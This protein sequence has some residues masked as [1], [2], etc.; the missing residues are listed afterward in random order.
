MKIAIGTTY[1]FEDEPCLN[2]KEVNRKTPDEQSRH[3]YQI[4]TVIRNDKPVEFMLDLGAETDY[5]GVSQFN[6]PGGA[7]NEST[8]KIYVEETVGRLREIAEGLRERKPEIIGVP[9]LIQGYAEL[10]VQ[11]SRTL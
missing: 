9:D 6:I 8:G 4:V 11:R 1:V 5:V 10:E 3:R 7:V 2:L